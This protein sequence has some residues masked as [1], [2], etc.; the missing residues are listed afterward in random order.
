LKK[1]LIRQDGKLPEAYI[2][3]RDHPSLQ[4]PITLR[5][6]R[7]IPG[8]TRRHYLAVCLQPIFLLADWTLLVQ[9]FEIWIT[10]GVTKFFIYVHSMTPEVDALLRVYER[11]T[12]IEVERIHWAPLP[13][14]VN[15]SSEADPNLRVYRTEVIII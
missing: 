13:T 14:I 3:R 15:E 5:D 7:V 12:D 11:S 9:F 1:L 4:I 6:A 8:V 2:L 10:Q